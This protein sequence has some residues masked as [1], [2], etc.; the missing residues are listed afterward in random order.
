[1]IETMEE[2]HGIGLAAPQV[3]EGVRLFV[4]G[5]QEDSRSDEDEPAIVPVA[6]IN[7]EIIPVGSEIDTDWEGCLSI[8]EFAVRCR[9]TNGCGSA[10]SI[11]RVHASSCRSPIFPRASC[12]TK[13]I[14][15]TACCSSIG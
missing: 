7:P 10:R 6:F 13:T 1:M 14:I 4:A 8:P 3:H 5:L 9:A 12:S 15:S 11:A 2:Y